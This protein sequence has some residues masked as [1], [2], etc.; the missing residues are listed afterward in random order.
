[1]E[2]PEE[3]GLMAANIHP[4]D[5][6]QSDQASAAQIIEDFI[7]DGNVVMFGELKTRTEKCL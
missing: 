7:R 1:M 5:K 2:A 4:L 6:D 3:E